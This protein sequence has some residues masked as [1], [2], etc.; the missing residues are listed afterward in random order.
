VTSENSLA[1]EIVTS[2]EEN[3]GETSSFESSS[4]STIQTSTQQST[5]STEE[6]KK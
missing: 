6:G 4:V 3:T 2:I 1:T 5:L